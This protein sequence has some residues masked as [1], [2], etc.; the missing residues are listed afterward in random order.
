MPMS[1]RQRRKRGNKSPRCKTKN[2]IKREIIL[3]PIKENKWLQIYSFCYLLHK[4]S[5]LMFKKKVF[6]ILYKIDF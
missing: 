3:F 1:C 5:S 4:F 6:F 2:K